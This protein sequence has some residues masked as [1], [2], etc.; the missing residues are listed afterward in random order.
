MT[1]RKLRNTFVQIPA[2]TVVST[3]SAVITS[4]CTQA[5]VSH[6]CDQVKSL[7]DLCICP[8]VATMTRETLDEGIGIIT[9]LARPAF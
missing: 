5:I 3:E 4:T 9:N 8:A 7:E 6:S 1:G 2:A